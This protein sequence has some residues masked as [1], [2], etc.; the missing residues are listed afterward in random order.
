MAVLRIL[1]GLP[2]VVGGGRFFDK[3]GQRVAQP[4]Q[5][6][7]QNGVRVQIRQ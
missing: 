6:Y 4:G 2:Q 7:Q 3:E 1:R 5:Q